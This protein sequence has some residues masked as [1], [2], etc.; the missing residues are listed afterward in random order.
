MLHKKIGG[1]GIVLLLI[2]PFVTFMWENME[3]QGAF[4]RDLVIGVLMI[5][6][7]IWLDRLLWGIG[8]PEKSAIFWSNLATNSDRK[9]VLKQFFWTLS[10]WGHSSEFTCFGDTQKL[11]S[12]ALGVLYRYG[13][14][15]FIPYVVMLAAYV[16]RLL[17]NF[18]RKWYVSVL[19]LGLI[20]VSC[21]T[22]F[23][24]VYGSWYWILFYLCRWY[25]IS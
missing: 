16:G 8:M 12:G 15:A 23:E 21:V 4:F 11:Y 14:Y 18:R 20:I 9:R 1:E 19:G 17:K 24:L 6:G 22:D 2:L 25:F 5:T 7:I 3:R 10:P 13:V